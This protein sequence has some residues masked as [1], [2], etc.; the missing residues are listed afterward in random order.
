M[1]QCFRP[2][3]RMIV[4]VAGGGINRCSVYSH[5]RGYIYI[6]GWCTQLGPSK[7]ERE[8]VYGITA[9]T[10]CNALNTVHIPML[11]QREDAFPSSP[12]STYFLL[13]LGDSNNT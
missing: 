4:V 10:T 2:I 3:P 12:I 6:W 7:T 1:A 11:T 5:C 13:P 8:P 9:K